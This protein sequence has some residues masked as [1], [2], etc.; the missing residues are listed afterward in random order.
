MTVRFQHS[1]DIWR[2]FPELVPAVISVRGVSAG[3]SV[4]DRIAT[5]GELA[6]KRLATAS[7]GELPEIQAWRRAFSKMGLKPTQYRCASESLL[8]RFRKE[9][10]LPRLHPL[11]DLCNAVSIA[12]AIPVAVFDTSKIAEYVEVRRAAG[13]ETYVTF[14]GEREHP[15]AGEVIFADAER[16]AHARRWTN[17][18]SG[19]SA[20]R[21][22]TAD[23]LIVAEALHETAQSDVESLMVT[24][25]DE[26][27]ALWPV[28]P[29]AAIL[30]SSA[31]EFTV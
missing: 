25:I 1:S 24:L 30:S 14:S 16:M 5:F 19:Y 6:A 3:V 12:Y 11:I 28:T 22:T 17:R 27:A 2:D 4:E 26:L 29:R 23:V 20:I 8:R 15:P 21:D 18:Q 9:G 31:P 13:D 7:E 10:S